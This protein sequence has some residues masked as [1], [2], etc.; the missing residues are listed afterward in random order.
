MT[1]RQNI[2]RLLLAGLLM[3]MLILPIMSVAADNDAVVNDGT[4]FTLF[5]TEEQDLGNIVN[6]DCSDGGSDGGCGG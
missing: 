4:H 5:Q 6:G 2:S 1:I 3:A